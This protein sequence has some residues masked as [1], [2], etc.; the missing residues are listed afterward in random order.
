MEITCAFGT[1]MQCPCARRAI[2][3]SD[4]VCV[5]ACLLMCMHVYFFTIT[6]CPRAISAVSKY[7]CVLMHVQRVCARVLVHV[8]VCPCARRV[9]SDSAHVCVCVCVL[10]H[11]HACAFGTIMQCRCARIREILSYA[12]YLDHFAAFGHRKIRVIP[13][14]NHKLRK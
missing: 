2:S 13:Q 10:A 5:P 3:N 6:Q 12:Y 4:Q 14:C 1:I 7:V 9:I 8:R 11:V